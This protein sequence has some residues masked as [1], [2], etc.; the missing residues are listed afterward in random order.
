[1]EAGCKILE[2]IRMKQTGSRPSQED[3]LTLERRKEIEAA[4]ARRDLEFLRQA[5][6][7]DNQE[8]SEYAERFLEK[9]LEQIRSERDRSEAF[10]RKKNL[11]VS[12]HPEES[13]ASGES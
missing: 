11:S 4:Y 5:L 3:R 9:A 7:T 1:M 10:L 6:A 2:E 8:V 13:E 12:D